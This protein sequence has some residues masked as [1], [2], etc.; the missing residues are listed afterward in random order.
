VKTHVQARY[1]ISLGS[2]GPSGRTAVQV[3]IRFRIEN[4]NVRTTMH[5]CAS[6][7]SLVLHIMAFHVLQGIHDSA[8]M[9]VPL[10]HAGLP[11]ACVF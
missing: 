3:R 6:S 2:A 7:N 5:H 9:S 11:F 10:C 4:Q 1:V 8:D